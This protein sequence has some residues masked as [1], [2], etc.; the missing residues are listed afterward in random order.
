MIEL[1]DIFSQFIQKNK[2]LIEYGS[3]IRLMIK[4]G[5]ILTPHYFSLTQIK[6]SINISSLDIK[7][8]DTINLLKEILEK[9]NVADKLIIE[10]LH[11]MNM[12]LS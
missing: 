4:V 2:E 9:Y 6:F 8:S 11:L 5:D 1:F 3:L 12:I 10:V 7:K